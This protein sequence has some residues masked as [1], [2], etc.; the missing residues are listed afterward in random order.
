VLV[1]HTGAGTRVAAL[2]GAARTNRAKRHWAPSLGDLQAQIPKG[3]L[4]LTCQAQNNPLVKRYFDPK[5]LSVSLKRLF[6]P[7]GLFL[8]S[9][10]DIM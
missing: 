2:E 6:V 4:Y 1:P 5:L 9:G 3:V 10:N 7:N 8:P